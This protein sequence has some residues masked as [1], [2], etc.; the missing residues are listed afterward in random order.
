MKHSIDAWLPY[1]DMMIRISADYQRKYPM[2]ETDDLQ[3]EMY[4]WFASHPKKFKEWSALE[5]KDRDK[6]IAKSL[7]NQCL[8]Y[9]ERE[10]ARTRGYDITDLYYYDASV[11]EAFL[12]TIIAESYE[13]P[14]KIK[15]LN[16]KFAGG[17]ISDG[18]NWLALRSDIASAFY[19]LSEAKQNILRLRF[20]NPEAEWGKVAEEM[21]TTPDG[22]RMKVQRSLASLIQ[23]LGGWKPYY[24]ED[25]TQEESSGQANKQSDTE[26]DSE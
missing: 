2:V 5:E 11:V 8:K 25:T 7:R 9:C 21:K 17:E 1:K 4:L 6:L 26:Y 18:M 19:A 23:H 14:A 15:D 10:K 24:D 20:S 12:P 16:T 3:Q 22:A 13:L